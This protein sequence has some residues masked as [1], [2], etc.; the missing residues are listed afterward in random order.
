[1]ANTPPL[2]ICRVQPTFGEARTFGMRH[3][4]HKAMPVRVACFGGVRP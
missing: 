3:P 2:S 4:I 1:M